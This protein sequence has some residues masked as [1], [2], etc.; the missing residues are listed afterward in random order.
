MLSEEMAVGCLLF[1]FEAGLEL[2]HGSLVRV[3]GGR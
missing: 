2:F 3:I 1:M